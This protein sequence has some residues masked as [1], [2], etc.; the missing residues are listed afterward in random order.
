MLQKQLDP[1]MHKPEKISRRSFVSSSLV[2]GGALLLPQCSQPKSSWQYFT[3]DEGLLMD[4]IAEQIIP[5]DEFPGGKDAGVTNFIDQ[6]LISNY[7]RFQPMYREGLSK[8]D[9][10][11]K[12][13]FARPF[14]NIHVAAQ[15]KVLKAMELGLVP[16]GIWKGR[17]S[18]QFFKMLRNH[19]MQGYYGDPQHGGN[20]NYV[21][22]QM[23]G[24]R[25]MKY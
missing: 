2:L 22:Y 7:K 5:T 20:K 17:Q 23:L 4:E 19:C 12:I 16:G 21:S 6:Q 3:F 13:M 18:Q 1:K 10:S 14:F 24:L 9:K 11:S 15:T 8:L 25:V